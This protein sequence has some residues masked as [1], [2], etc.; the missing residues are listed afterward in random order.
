MMIPTTR[1]FKK[2]YVDLWEPHNPPL[3]LGGT[4]ISLL[5]N[6]FTCKAWVLL[7]QSKD[8]FLD[9]FKL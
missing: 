4:Y 5:L 1:K 2:I 9:I 8:E 6:K 3:L 7:F